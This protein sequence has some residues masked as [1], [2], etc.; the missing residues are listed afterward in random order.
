VHKL[1]FAIVRYVLFCYRVVFNIGKL[2]NVYCNNI[3]DEY[4]VLECWTSVARSTT[5]KS[6]YTARWPLRH[7]TLSDYYRS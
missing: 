2:I 5:L 6:C 4:Q 1:I 7:T 3:L